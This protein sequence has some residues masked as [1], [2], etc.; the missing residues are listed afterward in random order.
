MS[1]ETSTDVAATAVTSKAEVAESP[2]GLSHKQIRTILIGLMAGML[3]AALDQ[4]IVSTSIRT[5]ADDLQGLSAMAWVTTAYLIT[6]T[7]ATPIY[8][9]LSDI[10]GRRPLYVFAISIFVLG[11]LASSFSTSMLMLAGFRAIQGIG[12]GGLELDSMGM[13]TSTVFGLGRDLGAVGAVALGRSG[14]LYAGA[15]L[16][17]EQMPL[18]A[19][20]VLTE[21]RILLTTSR[22]LPRAALTALPSVL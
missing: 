14:A 6:S 4:T 12:A 10:F 15:N 19:S 16:E 20:V 5:I 13:A 9:K 2:A 22:R 7:I 8:G 18:S 11:S 17:L 1:T 3:L 21:S